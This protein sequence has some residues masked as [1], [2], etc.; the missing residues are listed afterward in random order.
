MVLHNSSVKLV[1][2]I[3]TGFR[4]QQCKTGFHT[5]A[6]TQQQCKTGF[7]PLVLHNSNV[8]LV[9][10]NGLFLLNGRSFEYL[11]W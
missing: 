6:F 3:I 11:A 8:K 7:K 9:Y 2:F 5:T 1:C 10:T 4:Q